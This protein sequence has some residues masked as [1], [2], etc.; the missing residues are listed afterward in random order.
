MNNETFNLSSLSKEELS[1]IL[2]TLLFSS[3]VD[4]CANW[5]KEN[6]INM[7]E[8]AKKIR[9]MYPQILIENVYVYESKDVEHNDDHTDEI[10]NMF[11][12]IRKER[13]ELI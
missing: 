11:P 12:E 8:V 7:M 1:T 13:L 6:S 3:S 5:Y 4:I 10:I 2:E 9:K